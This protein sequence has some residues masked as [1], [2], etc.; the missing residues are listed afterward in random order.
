[1]PSWFPAGRAH[2]PGWRFDAVGLLAVLGEASMTRHAQALTSSRLCMLPRL[3]PAPATFIK[4][5]RPLRLPSPPATVIGVFS[6]T[7]VNELNYFADM[8]HPISDLKP[9]Q[10]EVYNIGRSKKRPFGE[11]KPQHHINSKFIFIYSPYINSDY[12]TSRCQ[13]ITCSTL[14]QMVPA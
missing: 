4:S 14:E 10:V 12:A 3:M 6:G 7:R 1:M 5:S 13:T 11:T 8:I 2:E 9:F